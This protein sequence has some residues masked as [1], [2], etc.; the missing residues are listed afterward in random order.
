MTNTTIID[1]WRIDLTNLAFDKE[2]NDK[3]RLVGISKYSFISTSTK[4]SFLFILGL[5]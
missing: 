1:F 3:M 5:I 4:M 2:D